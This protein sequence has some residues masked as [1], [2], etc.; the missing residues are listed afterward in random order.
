MAVPGWGKEPMPTSDQPW[1]AERFVRFPPKW[2]L[3]LVPTAPRAA[4]A[5][6]VSL[7]TASRPVPLLAQRALWAA[8]RVAGARA[9]PGPRETW[10][11]PV[12]EDVLTGVWAEVAGHTGHRAA[13]FAV[14][15][16]RQSTRAAL[17][18]FACA[19]RR[20]LLVRVR[21][22]AAELALERAIADAA[23]GNPP[24]S[25]RVPAAVAGGEVEG[26]HW[27]AYETIATRPHAPLGSPG[28]A[29]FD[30]VSD[31]VERGLDRP[32]NVPEHWRGAHGDL[33]AWNLRRTNLG[34]WLIDWEDAG[35]A[36]P[37]ADRVYW[38][39]VAQTLRRRPVRPPAVD[40][41]PEAAAHWRRIVEARAADDD[42]ALH[43]RLLDL[44]G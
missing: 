33:T 9:L 3:V 25:F 31:L 36:P 8:A 4:T 17:T 21:A 5:L 18:L 14:Y 24:A 35:W 28:P 7:Y 13:A 29:L 38:S 34:R 30:E 19:G 1:A 12:P 41:H 27:V 43:Q 6:G 23:R 16:R 15:E 42:P 44:L 40:E 26:W 20:S 10:T 2:R 22:S 32:A 11:P 37:G 39:V